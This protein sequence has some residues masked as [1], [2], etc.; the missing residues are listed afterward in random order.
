MIDLVRLWGA[1]PGF[2][3][4][5]E[6]YT[7]EWI[8]R[9]RKINGALNELLEDGTLRELSEKFFDGVDVTPRG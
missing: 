5:W 2:G 6:L 3:D 7:P 4:R 9:P 8:E 1:D